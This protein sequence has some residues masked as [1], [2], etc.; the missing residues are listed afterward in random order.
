MA[1][2]SVGGCQFLVKGGEK[3]KANRLDKKAGELFEVE[4]KLSGGKI[5]LKVLANEKGPKTRVLKFKAKKGYKRVIGSR[6]HYTILEVVN[7]RGKK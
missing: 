1:V 7:S 4:D 6:P 2:I 3:L 5:K